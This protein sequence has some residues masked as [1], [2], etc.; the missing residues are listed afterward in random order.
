[1][2]FYRTDYCV[3]EWVE[4]PKRFEEMKQIAIKLS[5]GIPFVRI[6]LFEE[7]D[8]VYFSE[9]TLYPA[10]GCMPSNLENMMKLLADGLN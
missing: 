1:M 6:D 4:K 5:K 3:L 8:K 7:N 2:P 10:S 9:F